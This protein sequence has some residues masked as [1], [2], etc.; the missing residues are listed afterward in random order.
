MLLKTLRHQIDAIDSELVA[1]FGKRVA[2]SREIGRIKKQK[3]LPILDPSREDEI[4]TNVRKLAVEH[5][6]SPVI[7]EEI[8]QLLLDYS[9]MEMESQ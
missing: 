9:R 4:K 7:I 3:N 5:G 2:I 8:S 1:L 6:I